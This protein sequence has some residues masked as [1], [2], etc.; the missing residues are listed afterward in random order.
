MTMPT[1]F[2]VF[3]AFYEFR[4]KPPANFFA[5][6]REKDHLFSL[7]DFL[8]FVTDSRRR[9]HGIRSLFELMDGVVY[10]FTP[11]GDV[12]ELAFLH[13]DSSRFVIA[14]FTLTRREDQLHWALIGGPICDLAERTRELRSS[15]TDQNLH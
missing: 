9:D 4:I 3:E 10:I 5:M 7:A 2:N 14:G 8:D 6:R 15:F 12:R 13:A 1:S 11:V